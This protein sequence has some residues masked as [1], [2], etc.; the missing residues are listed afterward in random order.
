M[1]HV[2]SETSPEIEREV[3]HVEHFVSAIMY[4][5][6]CTYIDG[7]ICCFLELR[8]IPPAHGAADKCLLQ[9]EHRAQRLKQGSFLIE[10]RY[11]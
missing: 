6:I 11:A 2:S 4:A 7:N 10:L 5:Y 9:L 1:A 8:A 3:F